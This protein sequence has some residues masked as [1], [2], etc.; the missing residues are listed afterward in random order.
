MDDLW[1]ALTRYKMLEDKINDLKRQAWMNF[2]PTD[3]IDEMFAEAE[4][5]MAQLK[6][7]IDTNFEVKKVD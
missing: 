7:W 6:V 5:E 3:D 4:E 1:A 2:P